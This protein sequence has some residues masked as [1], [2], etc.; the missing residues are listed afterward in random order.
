MVCLALQ[1]NH[2]PTCF[3]QQR[4]YDEHGYRPPKRCLSC[5]A[6]RQR[7][8]QVRERCDIT[9]LGTWNLSD[10]SYHVGMVAHNA[11]R[12]V[13]SNAGYWLALVD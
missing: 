6:E 1:K 4:F 11:H 8:E 13:I 2:S 10:V 12:V 9:Y 3:V 5:Q 7:Q